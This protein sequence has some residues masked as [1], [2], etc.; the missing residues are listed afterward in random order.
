MKYDFDTIIDRKNTNSL[1]WDMFETELPMWVAD[2]DFPVAPEIT[3]AIERRAQHGIFGYAIVP[4]EY[5]ES[6]IN[7]WDRRHNFKMKKEQMLFSI[8]VMPAIS[9]M[10]RQLTEEKDEILIQTPVYHMFFKVIEDN[11]RQVVENELG[12][13]GKTYFIDFDDLEEKLS[14]E[15]TKMMLLCNPHNPV[16]RIWTKEELQKID[17]LCKKYDVIIISDE[18]HCDLVNPGK[19]YIPF[20]NITM[21]NDNV[22]TCIAPTKTFNIAG[23]QS[24]IVHITNKSLYDK[25]K[26]RLLLDDSSQINVFSIVATIAAFKES[27]EWLTQLNEYIYQNKMFVEEYLGDN[28]SSIKFVES[29]ATY[30]LWLDCTALNIKSNDFKDLLNE[31]TGLLISPGI[32]FGEKGDNFL[33]LNVACP[34]EMLLD[35]LKRLKTVT[36][37]LLN[38]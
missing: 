6:Y 22:I 31:K 12:Y 9:S 35:G 32:E 17:A 36:D 14:Q 21:N 29:E 2:M 28:I 4:E 3:K 34:K 11:N 7:W 18:I 13:D 25:I 20:E 8:G 27:E 5:Y 23:I 10:I 24:S 16:G 15:S 19:S 38:S 26:E 33:R 1:K 30:L 37:E